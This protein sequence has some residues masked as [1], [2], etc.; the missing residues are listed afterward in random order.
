M[1]FRES[2]Q[3]ELL[4]A[5]RQSGGERSVSTI[6]YLIALQVSRQ[7]TRGRLMH[8]E[9][10][11][12]QGK[13]KELAGALANSGQQEGRQLAQVLLENTAEEPQQLA[14]RSWAFDSVGTYWHF[15]ESS[16]GIY[17]C[18]MLT[19]LLWLV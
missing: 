6:L 4:T 17:H 8:V 19:L 11:V 5:H 13:Q 2:E 1:K 14:V 18:Q 9:G 3:L 16:T 10:D 12:R 7:C 15:T